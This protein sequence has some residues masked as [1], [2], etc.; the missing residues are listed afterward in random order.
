[1]T[2]EAL[3]AALKDGGPIANQ[4]V[5]A[6]SRAAGRGSAASSEAS[7]SWFAPLPSRPSSSKRAP[8]SIGA[9][10]SKHR[11][12][13]APIDGQPGQGV[14]TASS[15]APACLLYTSDAADDM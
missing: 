1:M 4:K 8:S 15:S 10:S 3:E 6:T 2:D 7:S 14:G 13:I 9:A 11:R 5:G 12:V